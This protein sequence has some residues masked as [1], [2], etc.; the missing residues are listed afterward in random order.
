MFD[1]FEE[2]IAEQMYRL[3]TI[4]VIPG[5]LLTQARDCQ[6]ELPLALLALMDRHDDLDD[7]QRE[8]MNEIILTHRENPVALWIAS[9]LA[10]KD[11]DLLQIADYVRK[12]TPQVAPETLAFFGRAFAEHENYTQAIEFLERAIE[13]K[14]DQ[15]SWLHTLAHSYEGMGDLESAVE[16]MEKAVSKNSWYFDCLGL[17]YSKLDRDDQ[18]LE[19]NQKAIEHSHDNAKAWNNMGVIYSQ[20][21]DHDKAYECYETALEI[22]SEFIWSLRNITS[23]F[24]KLEDFERA[25]Q[26][27]LRTLAVEENDDTNWALLANSY[28]GLEKY[29]EAIQALERAVELNSE[30]AEHYHH[31]GLC[32]G[33]LEEFD[34]RVFY[35]SRAIEKNPQYAEA[36]VSRG[37]A[38]FNQ[39]ADYAT[40][41]KDYETAI[42]IRPSYALAHA[43]LGHAL[44]ELGEVK[45]AQGEYEVALKLSNEEKLDAELLNQIAYNMIT[46]RLPD[47]AAEALA[48]GLEKDPNYSYLYATKGLLHFR[49]GD[50]ARGR[51]LYEQAISMSP[52][53]LA[54]RQKFHY[55]HG[56]TLRIQGKF[57]EAIKELE[58]ALDTAS[59]Y[60]LGEQ[61]EAEIQK[62]KREE[63]SG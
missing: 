20:R 2:F 8:Q 37:A 21:G 24:N 51:E 59:E 53:D 15:A 56:L 42:F 58:R 18:A 60:V 31:L 34:K 48:I 28:Y 1:S 29:Q 57:D 52:D 25:R 12:S 41:R 33:K 23:L 54:L 50:V 3:D 16:Y 6:D 19:C 62:A 61:V 63:D 26:Y 39:R 4:T 9:D 38:Y 40:A 7:R 30:N 35:Y 55:E 10:E 17:L 5:L 14:P 49:Q 46:L 45:K 44:L 36:Y 22:N 47:K 27:G 32:F 13:I 11:E 43:F